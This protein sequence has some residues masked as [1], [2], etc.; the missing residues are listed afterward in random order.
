MRDSL[1]V[2][3]VQKRQE[4]PE[5][6]TLYFTR[7]YDFEAGQYLTVFIEGSSVVEGK[8]YSISSRPDDKLMSITV[9]DVGG[10]FS[11][12]L[13]SRQT[14]DEVIISQAYG[15]FDPKNDKPLVGITA[16]CGLS[17]IWSI[18]SAQQAG[19]L[20]LSHKSPEYTVFEKELADSPL[21]VSNF[22]TRKQVQEV[23]GW[24]NGRFDV[25]KIALDA[26]GDEHFLVCGA[27]SFVRDVWQKLTASGIDEA[28]IST[29]TFFES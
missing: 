22:S 25:S 16:G 5:V 24:N 2:K 15:H 29:E 12:Y 27:L 18:M 14:G 7:P 13:C 17:P 23:N 26:S 1:A 11:S 19:R 10:E 4:N 28:R 8:A 9:K 21:E 3:V 6:V 20:Y